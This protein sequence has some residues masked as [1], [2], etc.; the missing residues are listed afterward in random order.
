MNS[1]FDWS[2]WWGFPSGNMQ[3]VMTFLD[4]YVQSLGSGGGY[5]HATVPHILV[6]VKGRPMVLVLFFQLVWGRVS[7]SQLCGTQRR[8]SPVPTSCLTIGVLGL[9][10]LPSRLYMGSRDLHFC[11]ARP[12]CTEPSPQATMIFLKIFLKTSFSFFQSAQ[13][14]P[15]LFTS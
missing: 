10:V 13:L 11:M 14:N 12:L 6:V 4:F 7:C 9:Q 3:M 2:L 15:K 5:T 1:P 8:H